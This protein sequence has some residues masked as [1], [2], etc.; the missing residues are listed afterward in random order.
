MDNTKCWWECGEME[1]LKYCLWECKIVQ[2]FWKTVQWLLKQ[3]SIELSYDQSISLLVIY[4]R[5][6]KTH[7]DRKWVHEK[8]I[9]EWF[10]IAEEGKLV[11][12]NWWIDKNVEYLYSGILFICKNLKY[13][14][15]YHTQ[16][17]IEN[18]MLNERSSP[19]KITYCMI[20]CI[21]NV[22]N[23]QI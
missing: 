7:G 17:N 9:T 18:I 19:H 12:I 20:P 16:I 5:E 3:L 23:R 1:I 8:F 21:W 10:K 13:D 2:P 11:S 22:H 4:P 15:C 6:L 14:V